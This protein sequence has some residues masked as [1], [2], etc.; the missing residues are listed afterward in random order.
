MSKGAMALAIVGGAFLL[1]GSLWLIIAGF[2]ESVGWG[3]SL[4]LF[5]SIAGLAFLIL[6][7]DRAKAPFFIELLG[8]G[9]V[10]IAMQMG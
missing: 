5:N 3:I 4:I 6:H 2:A 1:V 8:I 7:W 9:L 10:T